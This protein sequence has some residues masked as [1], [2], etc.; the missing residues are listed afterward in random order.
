M[1]NFIFFFFSR[2]SSGQIAQNKTNSN[3]TKAHTLYWKRMKMASEGPNGVISNMALSRVEKKD[4]K[5]V[6]FDIF[7][8]IMKLS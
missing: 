4:R 1:S 3:V 6:Q 2:K 7:M 8:I 5:E